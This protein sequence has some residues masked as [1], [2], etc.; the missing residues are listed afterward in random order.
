M[1]RWSAGG[2]QLPAPPLAAAQGNEFQLEVFHAV[3]CGLWPPNWTPGPQGEPAPTWHF[4]LAGVGEPGHERVRQQSSTA[5]SYGFGVSPRLG[6][7][8]GSY[9]KATRQEAGDAGN[10]QCMVRGCPENTHFLPSSPVLTEKMG[11]RPSFVGGKRGTLVHL[12]LERR[13]QHP[14]FW[15][16]L[17]KAPGS[18]SQWQ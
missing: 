14:P 4:E 6:N 10:R 13:P 18:P 9:Q 1:V 2:C 8:D 15:E 11:F 7:L 16:R 12:G 17:G 5:G 3:S